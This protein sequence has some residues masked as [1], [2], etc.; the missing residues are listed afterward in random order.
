MERK[1]ALITGAS[2]GIGRATAVRFASEG[3]DVF[4]NGRNVDRLNAVF[5]G[6]G[7]GNHLMYAGDYA[8]EAVIA[9]AAELIRGEWGVLD[10]LVNCAGIFEQVHLVDS[11][12]GEWHRI[13]DIMVNGAIHTTRLAAKLMSAGGSIVHV[14]SVHGTHVEF[15]A[16]SYAAA[17]AAINQYCR[18]AALELADVGIRV[19]AIAP[20]YINTPMS[21]VNGVNENDT[22]L[23]HQKY[24]SG[25]LMPMRRAAEPEEIAGVALFL[26]GKD[27]SYI[28][29]QI[30][31]VD[32]GLTITF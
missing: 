5:S 32:G 29:G 14:T 13:F 31:A 12:L 27:A 23:F 7:A 6:L 4:L 11:T 3:Y 1:K 18:S 30:I 28:T 22:P 21:I 16:S 25:G 10:V 20:G 24:V 15:G 8:D 9:K 17:K 19:N 2:S 26:A